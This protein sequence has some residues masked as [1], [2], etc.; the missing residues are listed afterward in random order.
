[1]KLVCI[2]MIII[3]THNRI[4]QQVKSLKYLD[5]CLDLRVRCLGLG[6]NLR[7]RYLDFGLGLGTQVLVNNTAGYCG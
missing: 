5:L 6:L 7:V 4:C 1:M 3:V 2:C